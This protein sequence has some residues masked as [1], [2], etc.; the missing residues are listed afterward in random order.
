MYESFPNDE[1]RFQILLSEMSLLQGRF[2][3]YD[4]LIFRQRSWM[5]TVVVATLGAAISLEEPQLIVLGGAVP[6]LFWLYETIW[7]AAYWHKYVVRYRFIRDSLNSGAQIEE[8]NLYDLTHHYGS[9]PSTWEVFRTCAG[10]FEPIIFYL[11]LVAVT[12]VV[13]GII[14]AL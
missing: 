10:R 13:W 2:D 4:D 5:V 1:H 7:R 8:F 6:V 14:P 9:R 3:K 11:S 12:L